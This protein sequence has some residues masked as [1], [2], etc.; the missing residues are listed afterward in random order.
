MACTTQFDN[1]LNIAEI[2]TMDQMN[3]PSPYCKLA[4]QMIIAEARHE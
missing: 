1:N 4:L 3:L 2:L